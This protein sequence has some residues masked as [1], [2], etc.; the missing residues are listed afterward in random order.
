VS[1]AATVT[2]CD[3]SL[4]AGGVNDGGEHDTAVALSTWHVT[5]DKFASVAVNATVGV[6]SFVGDDPLVMW[7]AGLV[8]STVNVTAPLPV[9]PAVSVAVTVTVCD[10]SSSADGVNDGGEHDTGG[11]LSTW[12]V[13]ADRFASVAV[14]AMVGVASLVGDDPLVMCTS[15]LVVSTVNVTTAGE[16]S[17]YVF[18]VSDDDVESARLAVTATVCAPSLSPGGV[19]GELQ[20]VRAAP[21]VLH[22]KVAPDDGVELNVTRGA[23]VGLLAGPIAVVCGG[24]VS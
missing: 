2:V 5:V 11:A 21:S 3:P 6:E 22:W 17:E 23:L 24:C 19:N 16:G 20:A 1:V 12:H 4:S 18:A 10:P 7:T 9:F 15:G 13:T 8:V 14:N